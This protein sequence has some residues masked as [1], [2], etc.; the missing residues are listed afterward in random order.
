MKFELKNKKIESS[1]KFE[2]QFIN[3]EALLAYFYIMYIVQFL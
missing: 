2:Q 1:I 3:N